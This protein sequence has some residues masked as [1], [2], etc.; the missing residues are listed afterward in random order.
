MYVLGFISHTCVYGL[1]ILRIISVCFSSLK[2]LAVC[3]NVPIHLV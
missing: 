1:L 3:D 2:P